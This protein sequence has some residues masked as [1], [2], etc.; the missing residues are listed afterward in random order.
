MPVLAG[1]LAQQLEPVGLVA[2]L[3]LGQCEQDGALLAAAVLGKI[4][5]D[6]RLGAFIGE[7]LAPALD[8]RGRW[9]GRRELGV[10]GV[11]AG[12]AP[13]VGARRGGPRL[14]AARRGVCG[15]ILLRIV[16]IRFS[17]LRHENSWIWSGMVRPHCDSRVPRNSAHF[18]PVIL[19]GKFRDPVIGLL[20]RGVRR[21][22]SATMVSP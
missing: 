13:G 8:V 10:E 15:G 9:V 3:G 21:A 16:V 6:G 1:V 2:P 14:G 22:G 17:G 12:A 5:V 20:R 11:E 4:A 7:V 19:S 18:R